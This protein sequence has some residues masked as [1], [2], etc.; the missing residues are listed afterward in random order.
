V[1]V[2]HVHQR[3]EVVDGGS[4]GVSR[5]NVGCPVDFSLSNALN[6]FDVHVLGAAAGIFSS[7]F[8]LR[9][10]FF[11]VLIASLFINKYYLFKKEATWL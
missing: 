5:L 7:E 3:F 1:L 10:V 6:Q 8:R 11:Q 2:K 9:L 4:E